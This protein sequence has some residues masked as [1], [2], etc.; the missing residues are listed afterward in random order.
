MMT[1]LVSLE[2]GLIKLNVHCKNPD[3]RDDDCEIEITA[4]TMFPENTDGK[5][6]L[7]I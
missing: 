6:F 2:S 3:I 4:T 7:I 5:F 1:A